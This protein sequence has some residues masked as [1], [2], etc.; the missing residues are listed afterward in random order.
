MDKVYFRHGRV[1]DEQKKLLSDIAEAI[2]EKKNLVAH[3]PTGMGKT[4]AALGPA[5]TR[6]LETGQ[7]VFFVTPKISQHEVAVELVKDLHEKYDIDIRAADI[8]G[9]KHV[10]ADEAL[11]EAPSTE[12]YEICNKR[13]KS[14]KCP[15]YG[16]AKGYSL[17]EKKEAQER[18]NTFLAWYEPGKTHE[19]AANHIS[20]LPEPPCGYEALSEAGKRANLIICDYYHVL[21][22]FISKTFLAKINKTLE[23]SILIIDEA[24]NAPSRVRDS[25]SRKIGTSTLKRAMKECTVLENDELKKELSRIKQAIEKQGRTLKKDQKEKLIS[26]NTIPIPSR[27]TLKELKETGMEYMEKM[28]KNTSSCLSLQSFYE[29]WKQ[30]KKAFIRTIEKWKT[31]GGHSVSHRCLDPS[32]Y[33]EKIIKKTNSTILMSGTLKPQEMYR[34]LLGLEESRTELKEYSS[35]FPTRNKLRLIVPSVTT[36]YTE[37]GTQQYKKIAENINQ[38]VKETPGN[39]AVF[40]PSYMLLKNVSKYLDRTEKP[41]LVQRSK[42]SQ[43]ESNRLLRRFRD[44]AYSNGAVLLGVSGGSYGEG[45]DLPGQELVNVMVVGVPLKEPN[46]ETKALIEYHDQKYGK[47][48]EYGYIFPAMAK[49]VQAGGRCI[50][51][52][53]DKGTVIYLDERYTWRN[54]SRCFPRTPPPKITENPKEEVTKF[55]ETSNPASELGSI[56]DE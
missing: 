18:I 39:S 46:L 24:H 16:Y 54:Y 55:W 28:N 7:T 6:A 29:E 20:G 5:I 12:F 53:K 33:T 32:L 50:R 41:V 37:R 2:K 35:P 4:D 19:E 23:N 17:R 43:K 49:A 56:V 45:I 47:G 11:R 10:C 44:H 9:K 52:E 36:K 21:N 8:V 27:G 51:N 1:R 15:F 38:V 40:F 30:E 14:K 42:Q 31:G 13:V 22:P 48:W 3:A 34:D 25:L 26:K